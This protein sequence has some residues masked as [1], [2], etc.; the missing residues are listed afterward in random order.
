MRYLD[1]IRSMSRKYFSTRKLGPSLPAHVSLASFSE[2]SRGEGGLIEVN[3]LEAP[4]DCF[5]HLAHLTVKQGDH[6]ESN[7]S[8]GHFQGG[9]GGNET[10]Q[11]WIV[12]PPDYP[13]R[14]E[15][16]GPDTSLPPSFR[17]CKILQ[18]GRIIWTVFQ[19]AS[20]QFFRASRF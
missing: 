7:K 16:G 15:G 6:V 5:V 13:P 9:G 17:P 10:L 8:R 12:G 20:H 1:S 3:S 19:C 14:S 18:G 4:K 11:K 2:T